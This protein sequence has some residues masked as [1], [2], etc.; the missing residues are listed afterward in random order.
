MAKTRGDFS[1]I[2]IS[3]KVISPDQVEEARGLAN[4]TGVHLRDAL[5]KLNYASLKELW[6]AI[7][8]YHA[9]SPNRRPGWSARRSRPLAPAHRG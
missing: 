9:K 1:D 8:E 2:L 5:I 6:S 7:A 3:R 4:A